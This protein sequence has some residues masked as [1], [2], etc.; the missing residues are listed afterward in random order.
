MKTW[1]LKR[2]VCS[3]C[4]I[5]TCW[6]TNTRKY[7]TYTLHTDTHTVSSSASDTSVWLVAKATKSMND[8]AIS[9]QQDSA[10]QERGMRGEKSGK[11]TMEKEKKRD[12]SSPGLWQVIIYLHLN[13]P[14]TGGEKWQFD[15][16]KGHQCVAV[17]LC[18]VNSFPTVTVTRLCSPRFL[19]LLHLLWCQ[20]TPPLDSVLFVLVEAL[21]DRAPTV[22]NGDVIELRGHW[23][24]DDEDGFLFL[25]TAPSSD[26]SL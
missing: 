26:M 19:W 20:W 6:Y 12:Q 16:P 15:F 18:Q 9:A 4:I 13:H 11:R 8:P 10:C 5:L 22:T 25:F 7:T 23:W 17:F 1:S 3:R 24:R 21:S 2:S 14:S